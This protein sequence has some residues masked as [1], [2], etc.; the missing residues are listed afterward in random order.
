MLAEK[1]LLSR[2]PAL[3]ELQKFYGIKNL[4]K[5]SFVKILTNGRKIDFADAFGLIKGSYFLKAS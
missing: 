1:F 4:V 3:Q 2:A 5:L